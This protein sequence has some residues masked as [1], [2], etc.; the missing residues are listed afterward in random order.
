MA[1]GLKA[2]QVTPAEEFGQPER[3]KQQYVFATVNHPGEHLPPPFGE[4]TIL[5]LR[6]PKARSSP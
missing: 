4:R 5:C 2:D 1:V 6:S 3:P